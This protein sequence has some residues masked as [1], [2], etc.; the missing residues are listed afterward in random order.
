MGISTFDIKKLKNEL[1]SFLCQIFN[2]ILSGCSS[3]QRMVGSYN[4]FIYKSDGDK[5]NTE[6]SK[7]DL[8]LLFVWAQE[9][10]E[11]NSRLCFSK[12]L[13]FIVCIIKV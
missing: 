9:T 8:L 10:S 1:T 5:L 3:E 2:D 13:E 6:T 12:S 11:D 7:E 4:V